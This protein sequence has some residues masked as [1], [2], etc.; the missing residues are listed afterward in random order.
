V[1][2]V[3]LPERKEVPVARLM[4]VPISLMLAAAAATALG[5]ARAEDSLKLAVGAPN[6]WDTSIP[7]LGQRAGIFKKHGLDLELLYTNGGGETM[8]A[9]ISGSVDIGIAAGTGGVLGAFAKGAPVRILLAG[10]T[11]TSDLYWYV[12]ADSPLKSFADLEGKT[13]GYSTNG[14]ST[15]ATLLALMRHFNVAAKPVP[16]GAS[17][18]TLTQ[19]MS[20][21]IDVGWASPPFGLDA[22]DAGRIRLIARGSDAPATRGQTV[23]V[24]IVNASVLTRRSEAIDRFVAAYRETYE[25][26]YVSPE[27]VKLYADYAKISEHLAIRI[28]DEFL[29]KPAMSP[30]QVSGID[31]VTA[32][33]IVFKLMQVPLSGEQLA[34]L[35][36]IPPR[37]R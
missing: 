26:L 35:I 34:Q 25:W 32:D 15:H 16:T 7:E 36:R 4:Q 17:A 5:P 31:A 12:R 27:G 19:A 2:E 37:S 24:H 20:G 18:L 21:Q 11:G 13:V 14:A 1:I 29:P 22:L 30:D 6:N 28:R 3:R 33:A 9:V 8:Q 10:T 23:R